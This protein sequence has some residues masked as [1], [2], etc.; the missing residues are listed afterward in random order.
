MLTI[1]V[2]ELTGKGRKCHKCSEGNG[3]YLMSPYA[4]D[5]TVRLLF[6]GLYTRDRENIRHALDELAKASQQ[7]CLLLLNSKYITGRYK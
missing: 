5:S 6:V 2:V 4:R 3:S 7:V 1:R